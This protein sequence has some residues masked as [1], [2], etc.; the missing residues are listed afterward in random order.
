MMIKL[1]IAALVALGIAA[2]LWWF[3]FTPV[4]M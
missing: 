3:I 4:N 1:G 2:A